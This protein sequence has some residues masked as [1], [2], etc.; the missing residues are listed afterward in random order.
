MSAVDCDEC[1][2]SGE[3]TTDHPLDPDAKWTRCPTCN[4]KGEVEVES[5]Q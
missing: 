3:V 1:N 4:G 2:G 5:D